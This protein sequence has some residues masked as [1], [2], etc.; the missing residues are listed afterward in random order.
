[1]TNNYLDEGRKRVIAIAGTSLIHHIA[2]THQ[3]R[4]I[5]ATGQH[6]GADGILISG[7]RPEIQLDKPG[8]LLK[9]SLNSINHRTHIC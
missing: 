8:S 7:N 5:E 4:L 2:E 1:M 6:M 9:H 3:L